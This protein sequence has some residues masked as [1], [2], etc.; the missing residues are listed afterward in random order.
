MKMALE[1][2][3]DLVLMDIR[4]K[5]E[6]NGI[7]AAQ[8]ILSTLQVPIIFL[9]ANSDQATVGR[10]KV[11][12]PYGY[13]MKPFTDAALLTALTMAL[14]RH[15]HVAAVRKECDHLHQV[16]A[17][18]GQGPLFVKSSKRTVR[19]P[20]EDIH[21]V[22]SMRD[23]LGIHLKEKRYIVHSTMKEFEARLPLGDFM[24]IHRS[25]IVRLDKVMAIE[26]QTVIMDSGVGMLPIGITYY[27]DISQRVRSI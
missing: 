10:A 16:V 6:M 18:N 4:L 23:Y 22:E 15:C 17:G 5:G 11:V 12:E 20:M 1:L 21:Y 9:T 14:H 8:V 13:V 19:L 27:Q 2:R 26:G 24:R 3:P 7:E 25:F